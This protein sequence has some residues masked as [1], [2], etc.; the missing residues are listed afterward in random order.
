MAEMRASVTHDRS[1]VNHKRPALD[2]GHRLISY[3]PG[4][5]L[6]LALVR[7]LATILRDSTGRWP[8]Q[9]LRTRIHLSPMS[10]VWLRMQE[11]EYV[12]HGGEV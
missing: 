8:S 9:L 5:E 2:V 4:E 1:L 11:A 3:Q 6:A 10:S 12:K 7:K